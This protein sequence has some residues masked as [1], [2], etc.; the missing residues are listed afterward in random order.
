MIDTTDSMLRGLIIDGFTIGVSV[1]RPVDV[2]N[3]I[4]GNSIGVLLPL[5]R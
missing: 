3:L 2:G 5:S 4:Q 1:P